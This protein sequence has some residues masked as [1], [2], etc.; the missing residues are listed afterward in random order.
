[1][2]NSFDIDGV[3]FFGQDLGGVYPGP[4]DIIITGRSFEEKPETEAM[5][6]SK[7][8]KNEVFYNPLTF[9]Q[10]T[11][12]TSGVHKGCV[13]LNLLNTGFKIGIHF[14]DDPIQIEQIIKIVPQIRIVHLVHNLVE[15]E[16]VRH[17]SVGT[18]N[19]KNISNINDNSNIS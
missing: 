17:F 18:K 14:E 11:R 3:I 8:I 9:D 4:H 19:G 2:I 16:N 7:G 15:K 10:K 12:I 6:L 5:L 13:L 1:M